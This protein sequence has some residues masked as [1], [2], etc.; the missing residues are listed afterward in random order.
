MVY[1]PTRVWP[2]NLLRL[3]HLGGHPFRICLTEL[4]DGASAWIAFMST[5]LSSAHNCQLLAVET[6]L[7][8]HAGLSTA[9]PVLTTFVTHGNV[10]SGAC[11]YV[12]YAPSRYFFFYVHAGL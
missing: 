5:P 8:V 9:S 10:Q 7:I 6:F 3:M 4:S 12:S 2:P 1:F 11:L